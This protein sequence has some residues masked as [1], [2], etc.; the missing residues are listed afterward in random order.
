MV[1]P[2]AQIQILRDGEVIAAR[3]QQTH[4]FRTGRAFSTCT[5]AS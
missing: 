5:K 1:C 2:R 4:A 3:D